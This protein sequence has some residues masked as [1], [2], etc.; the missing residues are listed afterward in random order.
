MRQEN[1]L[2][3]KMVNGRKPHWI[4]RQGT[5][6]YVMTEMEEDSR[7]NFLTAEQIEVDRV[8]KEFAHDSVPKVFHC[9]E[10]YSSIRGL[11]GGEKMKRENKDYFI[12]RLRTVGYILTAEGLLGIRK[13][14]RKYFF[15]KRAGL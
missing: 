2:F 4:F 10:I 15:F 3:W 12:S 7:G 13:E 14:G 11:Q 5:R 8:R 9:D 1:L 6:Y